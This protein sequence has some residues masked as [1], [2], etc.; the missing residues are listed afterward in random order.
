MT[1]KN[2]INKERALACFAFCLA[3]LGL[4]FGQ[5]LSVNAASFEE[6]ALS[7]EATDKTT[8]MNMKK[9]DVADYEAFAKIL[10]GYSK[11]EL[12]FITL[13]N[14]EKALEDTTGKTAAEALKNN[15]THEEN[16]KKID[17]AIRNKD[18]EVVG[19]A[20]L[21][22]FDGGNDYG[23]VLTSSLLVDKNLEES[24][25]KAA[26]GL[27][28]NLLKALKDDESVSAYFAG[29]AKFVG[30]SEDVKNHAE[31]NPGFAM[32]TDLFNNVEKIEADAATY[33]KVRAS[34]T[35][36]ELKVISDSCDFLKDFGFEAF[37]A[38]KKDGFA[39]LKNICEVVNS[40]LENSFTKN[41]L[42]SLVAQS[43]VE[44]GA[45]QIKYNTLSEL[46]KGLKE[47]ASDLAKSF[48]AAK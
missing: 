17:Y 19:M 18:N 45:G 14:V 6:K 36:D 43:A 26:V 40:A 23:K 33:G 2:Y 48:L 21:L 47:N 41:M 8:E 29:V 16:G 39:K 32:L 12:K 28:A 11:D 20:N 44:K 46:I 3:F 25:K 9:A 37:C 31:K 30:S 7:F 1:I 4:I 10:M 35:A 38:Y 34:L 13:E 15:T 5:K 27:V 42:L 22:V 24:G